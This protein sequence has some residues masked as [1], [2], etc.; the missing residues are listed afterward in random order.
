VEP[1]R[2]TPKEPDVNTETRATRRYEI[3]VFLLAAIAL[4]FV[5]GP[6]DHR[7]DVTVVRGHTWIVNSDRT[8]LIF[9]GHRVSGPPLQ[10]FSINS[11]FRVA[12][13]VWHDGQLW[14]DNGPPGCLDTEIEGQALEMGLLEANATDEG[15]STVL[16]AWLKCV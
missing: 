13:A 15:P 5:H 7:G 16:V 2:R 14:H 6:T 8:A 10:M 1:G 9:K 4:V 11:G 12:G 3:T